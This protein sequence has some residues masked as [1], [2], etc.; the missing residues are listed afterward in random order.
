MH[1]NREDCEHQNRE[2]IGT[3][4]RCMDCQEP[5]DPPTVAW[6]LSFRSG[7]VITCPKLD[8]YA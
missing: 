6:Y 1:P 8:V 5:V 3:D 7:L 4:W 2:K